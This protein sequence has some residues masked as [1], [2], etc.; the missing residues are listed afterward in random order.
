MNFDKIVRMA[1]CYWSDEDESFVVKSPIFS[2]VIGT[3][4]TPTEAMAEFE[5]AL[6]RSRES[7]EESCEAAGVSKD[8][9]DATTEAM[10]VEI[11]VR[12]SRHTDRTLHKLMRRFEC[13]LDDA[14]D[15]LAMF[16]EHGELIKQKT[17]V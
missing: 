4:D 11:N 15:Y 7:Y 17:A 8:S 14:V 10:A 13:S 9:V 12:I 3:G 1:I 2:N 6:A 5:Q 16:Y